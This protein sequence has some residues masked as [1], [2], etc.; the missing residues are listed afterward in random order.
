M[1][2]HYL[3]TGVAKAKEEGFTPYV[4]FPE[5]TKVY[6]EK[7]LDIFG[8]R[9]IKTERSDIQKYLDFWNISKEYQNDKFYLLAYTQGMLSTDNFEFLADFHP[10]KDLRFVSE[11]CGH[12]YFEVTPGQLSVNDILT[13]KLE[14]D[15]TKD[16]Y[17]VKLFKGPKAIGYVKLVHSRVFHKKAK[18]PLTVR[19]KSIDQNG[20]VNRVFIDIFY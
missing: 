13:Y 14:K 17:A 12:S 11:I 5:T 8:Q 15:N 16:R 9:L 7:V 20:K 2:F 4:D 10:V 3:Q 19:V 6:T 1:Q 18:L